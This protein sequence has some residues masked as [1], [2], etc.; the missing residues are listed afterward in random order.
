MIARLG[1]DEL[2]ALV[3]RR[4]AAL[5]LAD[6]PFAT[7][8][9]VSNYLRHVAR[10]DGL[11]WAADIDGRALMLLQ[12]EAAAPGRARA[13][14][15]YYASL[16]SPFVGE[17]HEDDAL[18]LARALGDA[19]PALDSIELA[20]MAQDDADRV[21][22]AFRVAGWPTRRYSAFGNWH[23]PCEN[24]GFDDYMAARPSQTLNTWARKARRFQADGQTRL[25]L[26]TEPAEVAAAMR[27]Y[28]AVYARSWKRAEPYPGFVPG[29][30]ALCAERGWLRLGIAWSGSTPIAAQLWFTI[31]RR[32][33]IFKL[34][35]DQAFARLSAGT[36]LSAFMF[37]HALEVDRVVDI[38]Y[39]T[40]DDTYKR[41]WMT[42][43]RER[44]GIVACNPRTV[45]GALR[46]AYEWAG[47]T[48]QRMRTRSARAG[49]PAL[50][51]PAAS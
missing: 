39:L 50:S 20:P 1:R 30:A 3:E 6:N 10:D 35:Y 16:Y 38:D 40:G 46:A 14:T 25:Q 33:S 28:E 15:N 18:R 47:A 29:W 5:D 4:A 2:L 45:R 42:Q 51:E 21:E 27:A 44:V 41:A 13:L 23:L 26:V 43:R 49:E 22:T 17:V 37:R 48:R 31:R 9:W 34:A 36:V 8:A 11:Y 7:A 24:L 12:G 32:A 19:R